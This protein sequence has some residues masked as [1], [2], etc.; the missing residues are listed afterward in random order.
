[1]ST[2]VAFPG[3]RV[4]PQ[5]RGPSRRPRLRSVPE[6]QG[7]KIVILP[8]I[9]IERHADMADAD[10]AAVDMADMAKGDARGMNGHRPH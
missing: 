7:P 5:P 6:A 8:V 9:R 10:M 2:V 4:S 1:M 3:G